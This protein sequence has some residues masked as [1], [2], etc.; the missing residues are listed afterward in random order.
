VNDWDLQIDVFRKGIPLREDNP[1]SW[2]GVRVIHIPSGRVVTDQSTPSQL[3]NK[4]A[5]LAKL[6]DTDG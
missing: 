4:Q 3:L 2:P 1:D 6:Y 5:A